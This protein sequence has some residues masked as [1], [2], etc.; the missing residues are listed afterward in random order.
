MMMLSEI[1]KA[2]SGVMLGADVLCESVGS[3]SR[4]IVKNQLFVG[5]KG[6]RFDG[7]TYAL[8]AIKQGAAAVL[9]S[10]DNTQA[11]SAVIGTDTRSGSRAIGKL[12]AKQI[13]AAAGGGHRQQRQNHRE[14]NDSSDY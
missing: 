4:N 5:I 11:G 12:L 1:A 6:E 13:Q 3:D 8:E 7:N 14:R 9:V 10:D 2:V